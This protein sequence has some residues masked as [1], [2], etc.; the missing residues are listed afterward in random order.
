MSN[1][2]NWKVR[3]ADEIKYECTDAGEVE[4]IKGYEVKRMEEKTYGSFST[5]CGE[6]DEKVC[7]FDT[8]TDDDTDIQ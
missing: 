2:T 3:I 7:I 1:S 6:S 5:R 8:V 4:T